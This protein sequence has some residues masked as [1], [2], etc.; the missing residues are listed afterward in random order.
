M[1]TVTGNGFRTWRMDWQPLSGRSRYAA[2]QHYASDIFA[3]AAMGYFIGRFVFN[4]HQAHAGHH[5]WRDF[6]GARTLDG[7]AS[8]VRMGAAGVGVED[9][10]QAG[11][12]TMA[13]APLADSALFPDHQN[14]E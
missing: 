11:V 2:R 4:T 7:A 1:N 6:E 12:A 13:I 14:R 3:G 10:S 8:H 9:V 5:H